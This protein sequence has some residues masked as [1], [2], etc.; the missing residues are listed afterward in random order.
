[1]KLD[2][3]VMRTMNKQDFRVLAAVETG[4][5]GHSLVPIA[6]INSIANL[7]H[8]GTNKILSSLLRD[9]LLSHD[10]SCGYDGYRLTNSG[11][12]ILALHNLKSRGIIAGL[13]DKIGTGKES[14]CYVAITP[15]NTQIV[16]KFH[17]LGRTSFRDVKKKRDYFMVN[18]LSKNK[19]HGTQYRTLPNSWLFLSRTSAIKE[20]AFM[21][22]LYDVGYPTPKP[23]GQNRHIVAMS[24]VRG[25]PLYQL[26]S[27]RVSAE[28]AQSIF[29]QSAILAGRLA[30]HGLVHCDLNE[31][32]LI[33]DLSGV[34]SKIANSGVEGARNDDLDEEDR[35]WEDDATEHYVRHSGLPDRFK[36][37]LSS[38]APLEK[39]GIDGTGEV[40][41][42]A[43]P[44][45]AERLPGGDPKPIVTLIDFP[46]MISTRHP[47]AKELYERD[48]ECLKTFFSKK[49]KC[50]VEGES[51]ESR[52]GGIMPSWEELIANSNKDDADDTGDGSDDVTL[53]SKAQ[54]RL[55]EDLKASGYSEEDA[56]RD[57]ELMYYQAHQRSNR[58]LD[59]V[60]EEESDEEGSEEDCDEEEDAF[61]ADVN[62]VVEENEQA[63]ELLDLD[64]FHISQKNPNPDDGAS[65]AEGVSISGMSRM[66]QL[67]HA[68][69]EHIARERV[70]K[71][72]EDRKRAS[73]RKGAFKSRNSNK[74]YSKGRRVMNDFGI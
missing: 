37:A 46:Q 48:V 56:A 3:T 21:K 12:D 67:S 53:V 69:V 16:L 40:I 66:S 5:K 7:R 54:L 36:G 64:D 27:N 47:N 58:G 49:L 63:P 34:Q 59:D 33:V 9:K 28:Q 17:R 70:K 42:E 4:M 15:R 19:K 35:D 13:G 74:S 73:G 50:H 14:D 18:A 2:P 41:V 11:Y 24:V 30:Q 65:F 52:F 29:E 71:H 57:S 1:M 68:E 38:N 72:L 55:D 22:S 8:G 51:E 10:Q 44:Q 62:P 39:H 60:N 32:N 31:F 61:D 20:Y 26:H 23:L 43:P 45:P 6:L 25:L